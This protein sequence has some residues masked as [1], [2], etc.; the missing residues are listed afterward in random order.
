[1]GS[2]PSDRVK[3]SQEC[4]LYERGIYQWSAA[5]HQ[6]EPIKPETLHGLRKLDL[7][8]AKGT[9][10]PRLL[11]TIVKDYRLPKA[12][13]THPSCEDRQE[14]QTLEYCTSP[15]YGRRP[16][17]RKR[18]APADVSGQSG[19][20]PEPKG[21]TWGQEPRVQSSAT[22]GS[23]KSGRMV[24]AVGCRSHKLGIGTPRPVLIRSH[25][26]W[27]SGAVRPRSQDD[28]KWLRSRALNRRSRFRLSGPTSALFTRQL[29]VRSADAP[30]W[31]GTPRPQVPFA[32]EEHGLAIP[33]P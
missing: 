13:R 8:V 24:V 22:G 2:K 31:R 1:M 3:P 27:G 12:D 15:G 5:G 20:A 7:S 11:P 19:P 9:P 33:L 26:R 18:V 30:S 32:V 10:A 23:V 16:V 14:L 29:E 17:I 28:P 6:E 4:P 21:S 25:R